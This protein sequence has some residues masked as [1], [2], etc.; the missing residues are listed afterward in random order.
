MNKKGKMLAF[1]IVTAD[2]C[3]D[4]YFKAEL[5]EYADIS[6]GSL[7]TSLVKD[8]EK[9]IISDHY[10][11][12]LY[13][14]LYELTERLGLEETGDSSFDIPLDV[15]LSELRQAL[16]DEGIQEVDFFEKL[17]KHGRGYTAK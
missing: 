16:L 5:E 15:N 4:P 3:P 13:N 11:D 1:Q 9:G 6:A 2:N 12:S 8:F 17:A 10:P 7:T 14:Y